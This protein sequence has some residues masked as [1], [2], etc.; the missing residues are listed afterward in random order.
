[1]SLPT[2][3]EASFRVMRGADTNLDRLITV[4]EPTPRLHPQEVIN[5]WRSLLAGALEEV[6][7]AAL[8]EAFQIAASSPTLPKTKK[9][10][11]AWL[12]FWT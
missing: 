11:W 9:P 6:R 2:Y 5:H 10:W 1:M 8:E 3:R 7:V 12:F 4:Y